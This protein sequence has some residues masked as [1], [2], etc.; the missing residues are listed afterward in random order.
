[1]WQ[2]QGRDE[3]SGKVRAGWARREGAR[4]DITS[5]MG[6]GGTRVVGDGTAGFDEARLVELRRTCEGWLGCSLTC[7]TGREMGRQGW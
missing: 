4:Q 1:M 2:A 7:R 3:M 6:T 5:R